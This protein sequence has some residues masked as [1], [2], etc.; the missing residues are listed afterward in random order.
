MSAAMTVEMSTEA[1]STGA[2][3]T[4]A[5]ADAYRPADGQR[6]LLASAALLLISP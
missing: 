2:P 3:R 1:V 5:A 4:A 6:L